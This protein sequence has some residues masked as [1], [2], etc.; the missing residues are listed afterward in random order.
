M[1]DLNKIVND[2][3]SNMESENFVENVVRKTLEKTITSVVED[4]FRSYGDF[5]N[6][7]KKHIEENLNINFESLGIEGYNGLVLAAVKEKLDKAITVK[8]IEKIKESIDNMLSDI[9]AEYTL[10]EIIEEVKGNSFKE[11]YE[12]DHDEKVKL[13]IEKSSDGYKRI[14]LDEDDN[15]PSY[16]FEYSY[17]IVIDKSGKPYSIEL[18]GKEI[19]TKTIMSGLYGLDELLFKI[20]A[21]GAKIILDKGEYVDDYEDDLYYRF[22]D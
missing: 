8:G 14:Y 22:E 21:S 9:K 1:I 4:V 18:K 19:S 15:D 2:T 7:L 10:T 16:K 3:L 6:K 20:Y 13:L 11:E 5:G 12:F 17:C